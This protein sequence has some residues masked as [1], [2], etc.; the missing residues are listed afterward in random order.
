MLGVEALKWAEAAAR[1][2]TAWVTAPRALRAEYLAFAWTCADAKQ[3]LRF[4]LDYEQELVDAVPPIEEP[5]PAWQPLP[6]SWH[7][8]RD[9]TRLA[10]HLVQLAID[11]PGAAEACEG[12]ASAD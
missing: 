2:E 5:E 4:L 3:R 8:S 7:D 11:H 1:L 10:R 9:R 6:L 12:H